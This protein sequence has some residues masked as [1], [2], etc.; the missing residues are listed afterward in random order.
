MADAKQDIQGRRI[1]A[2]DEG[3]PDYPVIQPGS[4]R[5]ARLGHGQQLPGLEASRT[6]QI[7]TIS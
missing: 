2:H 4:R 3:R 1:R 7:A 6:L 5:D